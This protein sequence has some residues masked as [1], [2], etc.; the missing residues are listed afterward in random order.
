MILS[1]SVKLFLSSQPTNRNL[2]L[3]YTNISIP[4][5]INTEDCTNLQRKT[6]QIYNIFSD[7]RKKDGFSGV[8]H[9]YLVD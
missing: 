8:W 7:S 5:V 4:S 6:C 9:S 2:L 1:R 3:K